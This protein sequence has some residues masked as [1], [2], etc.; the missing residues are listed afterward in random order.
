M[1]RSGL[2]RRGSSGSSSWRRWAGITVNCMVA[3]RCVARQMSGPYRRSR[4]DT[5][6]PVPAA[7]Q[8]WAAAQAPHACPPLSLDLQ[9]ALSSRV[10]VVSS[11]ITVCVCLCLPLL[12]S[13]ELSWSGRR[14]RRVSRS[15]CHL[16]PA[17]AA[18]AAAAIAAAA[19]LQIIDSHEQI[20]VSLV[21]AEA[22]VHKRLQMQ[23]C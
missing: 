12:C 10:L 13:F 11:H 6:L 7:A 8:P 1:R 21:L 16:F 5:W 14:R 2:K 20:L 19:Q 23:A 9:N 3:S 18:A 4:P 17:A 22:Q 15:T